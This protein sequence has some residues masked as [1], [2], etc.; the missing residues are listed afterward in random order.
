MTLWPRTP[1]HPD[2]ELD[3][4]QP[5]D[6]ALV[7]LTR[8]DPT[9]FALLYRRYASAV[10]QYCDRCLG[11]RTAAEDVASAVFMRALAAFPRYRETG[12]SFRSWL[13]A[14]AHNAIIDARRARRPIESLER[15]GDL[16]DRAASPEELALAALERRDITLL[17]ARLSPDQRAVVELR[18]QGLNDKEIAAALGRSPGA[19]RTI[20]YRAVQRLRALLGTNAAN[21]NREVD[22]V[23]L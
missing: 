15:V 16:A 21:A 4:P 7:A 18:L 3:D 19:V 11:D 2:E 17:L 1:P 10:F 9:A 14:I 6:E 8:I 23:A 13:F 20:Q 22:C 5:S 12:S